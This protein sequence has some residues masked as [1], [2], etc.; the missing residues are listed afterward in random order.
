MLNYARNKF[1]MCVWFLYVDYWST[2]FVNSQREAEWFRG[3]WM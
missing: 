2:A 3:A 1:S